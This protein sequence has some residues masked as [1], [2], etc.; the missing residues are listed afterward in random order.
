M[1]NPRRDAIVVEGRNA[2]EALQAACDRLNTTPNQVEYEVVDEGRS[3]VL[4]FLKGRTLKVRVWK[5]SQAQRMIAELVGGMFSRM[6]VETE[7]KVTRAEDAYEVD[8]ET[9]DADGLLI[10]RGG[11][12]LKALQHLVSR[13]VG[14][15]DETLRVRLDVAGYRR[16]R[17]EQL[18][19]KARDLAER[20]LTTQRDAVTEP[21]P[22]DERRIVHL[23][24]AED[25]RVETRAL[26]DGAI[27]RV[28]VSP[29]AG[30]RPSEDRGASG[31]RGRGGRS[32]RS[33]SGRDDRGRSGRGRRSSSERGSSRPSRRP[34]GGR[35]RRDDVRPAARDDGYDRDE[36]EPAEPRSS[37]E[38]RPR[39]RSEEHREEPVVAAT[40]APQGVEDQTS[41]EA[42]GPEKPDHRRPR[43]SRRT[44]PEDSYFNIPSSVEDDDVDGENSEEDGEKSPITWGRKRRPSRGRR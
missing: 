19:R 14:Q 21:L 11:E 24:L 12:T 9:S 39:R 13:M 35:G 18:R 44:S 20:A 27:K 31:G 17:H 4:G 8:L 26:G 32:D 7:L 30:A 38:R 43:K 25:E 5:K 36:R 29:M 1:D 41:D 2:E 42:R 3:G 34:R 16:R 23:A 28:A 10:G 33:T 37:R 6:G 15:K 22:A 40:Q